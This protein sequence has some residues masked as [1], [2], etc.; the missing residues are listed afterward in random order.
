MMISICLIKGWTMD[1]I[2]RMNEAMEY[3]E[4]NLAGEIRM[5]IAA[6]KAGCSEYHFTRFF[7][8]VAGLPPSGY[9]RRRRL[10]LAGFAL[11]KS[12]ASVVEIANRYGYDSPNSFTRAFQAQYGLTPSEARRSNTALPP[13]AR[14]SFAVS[15]MAVTD[16]EYRIVEKDASLVFGTSFETAAGVA[17]ETIPAFIEKC[18]ADHTT[19][20]MVSVARGT[21]QTLLSAVL[22]DQGEGRMRYMLCL[23]APAGGVP[24]EFETLMIPAR[25]WA[26]F[27]LVIEKPGEDS[28]VSVWKRIRTEWFPDA[29]YER[30][31]GPMLERCHWRE[32]GKMTVEAWVPVVK[33]PMKTN[34]NGRN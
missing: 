15:V 1:W 27:P 31:T 2:D 5:D 26:V 17:F 32:D 9:I 16:L 29:D 6:E 23:D 24:E 8:Y 20:R 3:I 10:S 14:I 33:K 34:A 22:L 4:E 11:Q 19:N 28:I 13:F 21:E 12:G 30:D 18:E 7:S 25:T